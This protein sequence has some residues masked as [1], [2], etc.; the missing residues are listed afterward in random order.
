MRTQ[1]DGIAVT[2][3]SIDVTAATAADAVVTLTA[4]ADHI[5]V[6]DTIICS[7]SAAGA[8]NLLVVSG[9]TT[10]LDVDIT[11][12]GDRQF[13]FSNRGGLH[14]ATKG[15]AVVITLDGVTSNDGKL[16]VYYR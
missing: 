11:V 2:T 8:G 13:S 16:N 6:I 9:S 1:P 10:L 3:A 14:N 5:H 4:D 12:T 7:Y 15:E